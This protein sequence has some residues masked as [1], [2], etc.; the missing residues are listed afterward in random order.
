[1]SFKEHLRNALDNVPGALLCTLMGKDGIAIDTVETSDSLEKELINAT[2]ELAAVMGHVL[3]AS[4]GLQSGAL[5]ELVLGGQELLVIVRPVTDE[6]FVALL[7]EP[8][9]NFGKGRYLLRILAPRLQDE[10]LA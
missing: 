1:M 5:S 10:L 3:A 4:S 9:G 7:M 6:Y 2:V 8:G